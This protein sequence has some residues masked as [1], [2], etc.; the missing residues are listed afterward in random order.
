M[1]C[2]EGEMSDGRCFLRVQAGEAGWR[3]GQTVQLLVLRWR[4]HCPAQGL[5]VSPVNQASTYLYILALKQ[6]LL[7]LKRSSCPLYCILPPPP[8]SHLVP[9][10]PHPLI[11]VFELSFCFPFTVPLLSPPSLMYRLTSLPIEVN[12]YPYQTVLSTVGCSGCQKTLKTRLVF[13]TTCS[14]H[15]RAFSGR[16][17]CDRLYYGEFCQYQD[18]CIKVV[19]K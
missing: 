1:R 17:R 14:G 12:G 5:Q 13:R 6:L 2:E 18:E 11:Q 9:V 3:V 8:H 10:S 4:G 16:C 19:A 7:P 15:G